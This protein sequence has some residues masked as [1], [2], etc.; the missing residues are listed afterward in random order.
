MGR[1]HN[2]KII[3]QEAMKIVMANN[4]LT[5][6]GGSERVMLDETQWLRRNGHSVTMFGRVSPSRTADMPYSELMPQLPDYS[7]SSGI[8]RIRIARDV[9]YNRDTGLR[10][11]ALLTS[12]QPD[13]VHCHNIY[14]GLTTAVVDECERASVPCVITLHDYKLVCPSYLMLRNGVPCSL[15]LGGKFYYCALTRCH[16][17]SFAVS[18]V[19]TVEAYFN[20]HYD[21]YLKAARLIAPSRFLLGQ[22][23]AGGIPSSK[24][25]CIP[26]GIDVSGIDLLR[27]DGGYCLYFGR[28]SE[29]K[30][31]KTLLSAMSNAPM[32]LRVAGEGPAAASLK[33]FAADEGLTNVRF[34]GHKSGQELIDLLGGATFVIVPSECYENASM[35]VLEAMAHG[36]SIVAS[37]IGGLPEQVEDGV[38]GLLF[39]PG[40]VKQLSAAMTAIWSD[41]DLRCKLGYAARQRAESQFSLECHC[42]AL[43]QLYEEVTGL[44][45]VHSAESAAEKIN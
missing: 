41:A 25:C 8:E 37:R 43:Q 5:L 3:E 1:I 9:V 26:N 4:H 28:L 36:K 30:G 14:A 7:A 17:S 33:Q 29:E 38:T 15:C 11:R 16:K 21:K 45:K 27:R 23:V 2:R 22:M 18:A 34:E 31:L 35:S 42:R 39:E 32:P 24:L 10:F 6:R 44:G 20:R 13:I 40:D 12:V 19:S